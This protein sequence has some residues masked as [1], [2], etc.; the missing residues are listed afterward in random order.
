MSTTAQLESGV[1]KEIEQMVA[2]K[3]NQSLGCVKRIWTICPILNHHLDF[4]LITI[5]QY[6]K[7]KRLLA[8]TTHST[9]LG[10]QT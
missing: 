9:R 2:N 5:R 10:S 4:Q 7:C 6:Q 3:V 1:S 8:Q